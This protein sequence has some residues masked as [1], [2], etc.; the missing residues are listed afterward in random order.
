MVYLYHI[1]Y[2]NEWDDLIPVVEK[3]ESLGGDGY[4]FDIF[5][6][7]VQLGDEDFVGKTKMDAVIKVLI[8]S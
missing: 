4:E 7:C 2:F 3:I 6:N 8:G 5:G 1:L